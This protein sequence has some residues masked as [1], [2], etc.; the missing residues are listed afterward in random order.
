MT[1]LC[2][3]LPPQTSG[4][5]NLT[6][7]A[8]APN[9][10][11]PG[12]ALTLFL[13]SQVMAVWNATDDGGKVVPN[14]F[15]HMVITQ[16]LT[17][18]TSIALNRGVYVD[19]YTQTAQV[20]LSAYPNLI[21]SGGSVQVS[22]SV[23]GSPAEG[24]GLFKVYAMNGEFLKTLDAVNGQAV[25]DLTNKEGRQVASGVYFI[26]FEVMDPVTEA[27]AHKTVKVVVLR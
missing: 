25:W 2:G 17:D 7:S 21:Y 4:N 22:A 8:F 1:T 27:K 10:S 23:E 9:T 6:V 19:P 3:N 14:S 12:G 15:Y 24:A 16:A 5:L 13:N 26:G 18:G 11:T 20:Q